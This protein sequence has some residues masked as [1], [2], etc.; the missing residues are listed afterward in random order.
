MVTL[1][2]IAENINNYALSAISRVNHF[3]LRITQCFKFIILNIKSNE[4]VDTGK[5]CTNFSRL[6]TTPKFDFLQKVMI[7]KFCS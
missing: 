5:Q 4:A 6:Y 7:L 2:F 3:K 1:S